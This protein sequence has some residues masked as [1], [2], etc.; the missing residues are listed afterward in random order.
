MHPDPQSALEESRRR[1]ALVGGGHG[2][3]RQT[4]RGWLVFLATV[5]VA[6]VAAAALDWF[7]IVDLHLFQR[8]ATIAA[9]QHPS[10]AS[11]KAVAVAARAVDS[12]AADLRRRQ[13]AIA[14]AEWRL[15]SE[16]APQQIAT[17]AAYRD[18]RP[19]SAQADSLAVRLR[20]LTAEIDSVQRT[21]S[22][23]RGIER[24]LFERLLK[25]QAELAALTPAAA[26]PVPVPVP[27]VEPS[28]P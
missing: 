3:Q 23:D 7:G 6:A 25:A 1:A 18:A 2:R 19:V 26:A 27:V 17:A 9:P 14:E 16:L 15:K 11:A 10:K 24:A 21:I 28:T 4:Q 12:I 5:L 8:S 20:N 13:T 22:H